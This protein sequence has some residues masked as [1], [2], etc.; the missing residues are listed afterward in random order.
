MNIKQQRAELAKLSPKKGAAA[1]EGDGIVT[2]LRDGTVNLVGAA[3]PSVKSFFSDIGACY[4]YHEAV[5]K[6]LL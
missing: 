3:V 4:R 1:P 6:G 2:A 5:R